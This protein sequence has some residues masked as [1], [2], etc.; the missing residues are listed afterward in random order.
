MTTTP[1]P[2]GPTSPPAS[3][4]PTAPEPS[5]L[6]RAHDR[7]LAAIEDMPISPEYITPQEILILVRHCVEYYVDFTQGL[8]PRDEEGEH[9]RV[10]QIPVPDASPQRHHFEPKPCRV[11]FEPLLTDP[12]GVWVPDGNIDWAQ[13]ILGLLRA[14]VCRRLEML[15]GR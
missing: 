14:A 9:V 2:S 15:H 7:T 3:P 11:R 13:L 6:M 8:E 1:P 5:V 10:Y 4:P 12:D